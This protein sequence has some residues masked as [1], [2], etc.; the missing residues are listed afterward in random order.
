MTATLTWETGGFAIG[1]AGS[2]CTAASILKWRVIKRLVVKW[3][4]R[5]PTSECHGVHGDSSECN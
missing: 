2:P 3:L 4:V 5:T 1:T